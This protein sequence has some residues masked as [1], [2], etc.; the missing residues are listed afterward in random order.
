MTDLLGVSPC[1]RYNANEPIG[2]SPFGRAVRKEQM[3]AGRRRGFT[4]VELLV[5]ISI[6]VILMSIL[7]PALR[8]ARSMVGVGMCA[9][10]IRTLNDGFHA[11]INEWAERLPWTTCFAN[12]GTE[13]TMNGNGTSG[14]GC[15]YDTKLIEDPELFFCPDV[16]VVGIACGAGPDIRQWHIDNYEDRFARR[17]KC[18][19]EYFLGYWVQ[20]FWGP[21][22]A[23]L[24][25]NQEGDKLETLKKDRVAWCADGW[26]CWAWCNSMC[27]RGKAHGHKFQNVGM[28]DGSVR[29]VPDF[30]HKLPQ[31]GVYGYYW[32]YN[33]RPMWGWWEYYGT[34]KGM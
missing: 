28:L 11:Y 19:S 32:P 22:P 33:D 17:Q 27:Y 10:R 23:R 34:G 3:D 2:E 7:L 25:K 13:V 8:Y 18:F 14:L 15:L 29:A 4:L 6:I 21:W 31:K 20:E 24:G 5:V 16:E 12:E 30:L 26:G 9:K 1:A